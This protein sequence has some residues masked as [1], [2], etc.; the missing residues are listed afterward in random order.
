MATIEAGWQ[1]Y[2]RL[3]WQFLL[4][5]LGCPIAIWLVGGLSSRY[6][7]ESAAEYL[8][9]ALLVACFIAFLVTGI[10][11]QTFRCPRCSERFSMR[12]FSQYSVFA[13]KCRHCGL[14]KFSLG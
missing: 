1:R 12:G 11:L 5:W 10:R 4:A 9:A 7:P 2:R 14:K 3:T 6:L 13:R 8:V